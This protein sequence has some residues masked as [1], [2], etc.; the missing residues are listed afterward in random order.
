M[1]AYYFALITA[2]IWGIAPI[3]EK[4]GLG[5]IEPLSGLLIRSL[6]VVIGATLLII[7]RTQALRGALAADA[8]TFFYLL[9]GGILASF[10]GQLF[11]YRALKTGQTS[12]V[13]P[14]AATYPLVSF[15]IAVFF[16]QEQLTLQKVIGVLLV[17]S[18]VLLLK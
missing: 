7:F 2:C 11:F 3:L 6:G 5:K 15:L 17:I 16:L 10:L 14:L 8:K 13:V 12:Q 18:G 4:I 9:L 1:K